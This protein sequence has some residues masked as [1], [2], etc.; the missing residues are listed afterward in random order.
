MS[1]IEFLGMAT[2]DLPMAVNIGRAG[3]ELMVY[4]RTPGPFP[5]SG[6]GDNDAVET[7]YGN[8]PLD[9]LCE[10]IKSRN[11]DPSHNPGTSRHPPFAGCAARYCRICA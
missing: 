10:L 6:Y 4:N 3:L 5:V 8:A 11:D 7:T 2:M 9:S 1:R